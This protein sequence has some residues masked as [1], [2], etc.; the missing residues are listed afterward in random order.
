MRL[1]AAG[2]RGEEMFSD[3]RVP[4]QPRPRGLAGLHRVA[5]LAARDQVAFRLVTAAHPRLYVVQC[6]LFRWSFHAAVHAAVSVPSEHTLTLHVSSY[7]VRECGGPFTRRPRA[8]TV[9]VVY[10]DLRLNRIAASLGARPPVAV[11]RSAEDRE[12]AVAL[13]LRASDQIELLMIKRA[14]RENDPW[15]GHMALPG[16]RRSADDADL[17]RTALRE[18]HEEIGI[19]IGTDQ[20]MGALDEVHPRSTRLPSVVVAPWVMVA[21]EGAELKPDPREVEIAIWVPVRALRD[22]A[23]VSELVL[24][25]GDF[26]RTFPSIVYGEYTI[27]GLTHRILTQFLDVIHDAGVE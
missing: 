9:C 17:L 4:R 21:P 11:P 6:Q 3:F 19:D 25:L 12:A 5:R 15:S 16:G 23:A 8:A 22:P 20:V 2:H 10:H 14:E 13:V 7:T 24:E 26:S 18:T 1:V 27:W